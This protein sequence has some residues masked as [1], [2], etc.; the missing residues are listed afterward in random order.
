M[1]LYTDITTSKIINHL[2]KKKKKL[3]ILIC[4]PPH[5]DLKVKPFQINFTLRKIP[6]VY[7]PISHCESLKTYKVTL[8]KKQMKLT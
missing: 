3:K 2:Q 1:V 4:H 8:V 7:Q 6:E 5:P